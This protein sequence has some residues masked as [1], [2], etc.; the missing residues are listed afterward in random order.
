MHST[1]AVYLVILS[2]QAAYCNDPNHQMCATSEA[3][4]HGGA[5]SKPVPRI[6]GEAINATYAP[7]QVGLIFV[8]KTSMEI[9][10]GCG[11]TIIS[12]RFVLTASHCLGHPLTKYAL[13]VVFG[14]LNYCTVMEAVREKPKGPWKNAVLAEQLYLHPDYVNA[15]KNDIAI[16][17]LSKELDFVK[18]K[19]LPACLPPRSDRL[20]HIRIVKSFSF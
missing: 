4:K 20:Y 5:M 3:G 14:S 11:G 17:K 2:F 6:V 13:V 19:V 18:G 1:A 12:R 10:G 8:N 7:F 15:A 9:G 16:I